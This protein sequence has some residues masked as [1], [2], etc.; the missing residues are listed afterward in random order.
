MF[1][2]EAGPDVTASGQTFVCNGLHISG[3]NNTIK[4]NFCRV[5]G[6]HNQIDG[7]NCVIQGNNNIVSGSGCIILGVN[8]RVTGT[9]CLYNGVFEGTYAPSNNDSNGPPSVIST[10]GSAFLEYRDGNDDDSSSTSTSSSGNSSSIPPPLEQHAIAQRNGSAASSS[11]S[12]SGE[13]Y[14]SPAFRFPRVYYESSSSS[15]ES[16]SSSSSSSSSTSSSSSPFIS[17]MEI[18]TLQRVHH[19]TP[20]DMALDSPPSD[21]NAGTCIIC[22]EHKATCAAFP[23]MHMSYCAGCAR[24]LCVDSVGQ[25]R[26]RGNVRCGKLFVPSTLK[27]ISVLASA[28]LQIYSL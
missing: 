1:D 24:S 11:P 13:E 16:S 3:D 9:R 23:C 14:N 25:A 17:P 26:R 5:T 10:S 28:F 6:N 27:F 2:Q 7:D 18:A 12:S 8:N 19:P 21:E 22:Q 15:S 20:T 4:G